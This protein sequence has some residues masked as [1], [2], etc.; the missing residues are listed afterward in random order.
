MLNFENYPESHEFAVVEKVVEVAIGSPQRRYRIEALRDLKTG[1]ITTQ[2]FVW[3]RID[4]VTVARWGADG[5]EQREER[6]I[7]TWIA[8]R[9]HMQSPLG[10][11]AD[12]AINYEIAHLPEPAARLEEHK[13]D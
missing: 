3:E 13:A 1:E 8:Y 7:R 10:L 5:R 2:V 12:E 6:S 11:T 4:P 9:K